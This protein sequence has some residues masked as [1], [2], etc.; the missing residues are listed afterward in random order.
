MDRKT[1][2]IMRKKQSESYIQRQSKQVQRQIL[3]GQVYYVA[4]SEVT[5]GSEMQKNRPGVIVSNNTH[6]YFSPTVEVVYM[7]SKPRKR[8][9]PTQFMTDVTPYPSTVLCEEVNTVDKSR[10]QRYVGMLPADKMAKLN[11][12]LAV[13][14]GLTE[15][16]K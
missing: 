14:L 11:K 8:P 3:R 6:N 15:T 16:K 13:S 7:T 12:C 9:L 4:A 10:L 2:S 5:K 1:K